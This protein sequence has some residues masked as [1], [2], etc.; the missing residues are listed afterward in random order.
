MD[1]WSLP[2]GQEMAMAMTAAHQRIKMKSMF[3]NLS[4]L[5]S[6]AC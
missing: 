2:F 5:P 6:N 1:S 3:K 4:D